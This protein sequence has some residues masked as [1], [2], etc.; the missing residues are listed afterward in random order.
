[1]A[2]ANIAQSSEVQL[3]EAFRNPNLQ[4][5]TQRLRNSA[6][7]V[8]TTASTIVGA[9]ST[10][11]D[12][13]QYF[14]TTFSEFG[15]PLSSAKRA[16]IEEWTQNMVIGVEESGSKGASS[17][18]G[19]RSSTSIDRIPVP[20]KGH[21]AKKLET[22]P[23]LLIVQ[24]SIEIAEQN[25]AKANY[26]E[27]E[28]FFRLGLNRVKTLRAS[29]QQVFHLNEV[30]LKIAF[31]RLHQR[32]INGAE[33]LFNSLLK[34][35][36]FLK[37]LFKASIAR[38]EV[39]RKIHAYFG[40]AQIYLGRSHLADAELMCKKCIDN[41]RATTGT[42]AN[43]LYSKTLQLMASIHQAKGDSKLAHL[44]SNL[45]VAEGLKANETTP[46]MLD[47]EQIQGFVEI[48]AIKRHERKTTERIL[49]ALDYELSN[50]DFNPTHA[51]TSVARICAG[52]L[53]GPGKLGQQLTPTSADI[54][55]I[56]KFL[57]DK[58]ANTDLPVLVACE[59]GNLPVVEHLCKADAAAV[60]GAHTKPPLII[61]AEKGHVAIAKFLCDRD[62]DIECRDIHGGTALHQAVESG[63]TAIVKLLLKRRVNVNA[64]SYNKRTPLHIAA[65]K[66]HLAIAEFLCDR[67]AKIEYTDS[68]N[69]TAIHQA[70]KS[71]Q[72]AIVE[73]LL[74]RGALINAQ[75]H[76][77]R[78]PLHMAAEKGHLA[79][80]EFLCDR[81]ANIECTDD[82]NDTALHQA[83]K[84]GQTAIVE[85]LLERGALINAQGH[86]GRT[87]LHV[88]VNNRELE[89]VKT[90][91]NAGADLEVRCKAGDTPLIR[92]LRP[93][94]FKDTDLDI[95]KMLCKRGADISA[96][97]RYGRSALDL[98]KS[99]GR[100]V[101][102]EVEKV[103]MH[104]I[105]CRKGSDSSNIVN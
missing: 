20:S 83:V 98:A 79:I 68:Y 99:A 48:A 104:T 30:L 39:S 1:M 9:K 100:Q 64:Q 42:K 65:E 74:E 15:V 72:T 44:F 36:G 26:P 52:D 84:S 69:D 80:A 28:N 14:P 37:S 10:Q 4:D 67:H 57:L 63:Q 95:L 88:A 76:D 35:K 40:L 11:G 12:G 25:W 77:G 105:K 34:S 89:V 71:G 58:G 31:T 41:W 61:A 82:Y 101:E 66:G 7:A 50:E 19:R 38:D 59:S 49:S 33:E 18:I 13:S 2:R 51:L 93:L 62:A 102:R 43:C 92:S 17:D 96:T 45:A 3:P 81:D 5:H 87:P 29:K 8:L 86:D 53:I 85:L 70:V 22:D 32:D 46:Y 97:T 75:G 47:A 16:G 60:N 94:F 78:T 91:C 21:A 23:D 73:L 103:F 56:V 24:H 6:D 54:V 90:L 55:S 27:A